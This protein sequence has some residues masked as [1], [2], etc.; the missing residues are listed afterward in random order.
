MVNY[1]THYDIYSFHRKI[2]SFYAILL[3]GELQR[4]RVD[5]NG[6]EDEWDW[7]V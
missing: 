1:V 5:M 3:G 2:F 7:D 6:L 4:Q